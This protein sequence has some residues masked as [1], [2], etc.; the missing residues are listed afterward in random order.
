MALFIPS[1]RAAVSCI[2]RVLGSAVALC[3][4]A[5]CG[6]GSG[7]GST[8]VPAPASVT[9]APTS[10]TVPIGTSQPFSAIA[11]GT[12]S[13]W[14]TWSATAG[15]I[16]QTGNY[17]APST[18]PAGGMAQV[19]ATSISSP[20]ASASAT[21]TITTQPVTLS[22]APAS[23]TL[24]A[25]F[26]EFY[27][28]TVGGTS[29]KLT[30]WTVNDSP[31]DTTYPGSISGGSYSAPAPVIGAHTYLI[32]VISN[33][34]PTKTASATVTVIPLENQEQ[35]AFPIKLG[36][37]GANGSAGDCCSG[38]LGSLIADQNGKQYI[39]S[40]NHVLGRLG[41][42]MPGEPVVQ[43]GYVDTFCDFSQPNTV[44]HFTAAPPIRTSNVDAAIAEVVAGAVDTQGQIIGLGGI[45][46]DG[47]YIAA[48]PA[49]TTAVPAVGMGVAKSGRT[50]GLS[51]GSVLA[52]DGELL[53]DYPAGC[54]NPSD[55]QILF[56][57]QVVIGDIAHPGDS[58]SLIVDAPTSRPLALVSGISSDGRYT[59]ANPASQILAVLGTATGLKFSFVGGP[60]HPVSC[61]A[62]SS[63]VGARL[64]G[65]DEAEAIQI[66]PEE[67]LRA[68]AVKDRHKGELLTDAAVLGIAVGRSELRRL[69][70]AIIVF[71]EKDKNLSSALP[72]VLE[73]VEVRMIATGRFLAVGESWSEALRCRARVNQSDAITPGE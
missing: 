9:I 13:L 66:S 61:S 62:P 27:S 47:S 36:T 51:C 65:K 6:G 28:A 22:I 14:V 50:T 21:V 31:G 17:I 68:V 25:G 7:G 20:S 45:A 1:R 43:P 58:G 3:V 63:A 40:N 54:G 15:V 24:K 72:L 11:S 12:T 2:L 16:D 23:A 10:A 57:G 73:G 53:V 71:V 56:T 33:A 39:L 5:G 4:C 34:D 70:A 19:T 60:E 64:Q 38:T 67:T 37:S 32:E 49:S 41:S 69:G 35:Q 52:V 46:A 18:M 8:P 29:N 55:Q 30:T 44:A 42:A 48:P 26:L 59:T